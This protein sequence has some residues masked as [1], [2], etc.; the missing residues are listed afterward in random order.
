M[1]W[2]TN[3]VI[4]LCMGIKLHT[5]INIFCVDVQLHQQTADFW[6]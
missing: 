1:A 6:K 2:I 4:A 5:N 3:A